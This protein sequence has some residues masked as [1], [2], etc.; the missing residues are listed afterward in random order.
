MHVSEALLWEQRFHQASER[1]VITTI[2]RGSDMLR[3]FSFLLEFEVDRVCC[4]LTQ[5]AAHFQPVSQAHKVETSK[6]R[7]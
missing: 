5:F 3:G 6:R 7:M 2:A 4:L 1:G